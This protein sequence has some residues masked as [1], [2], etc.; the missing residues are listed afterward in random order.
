MAETTTPD[1]ESPY[2]KALREWVCP[3]CLDRRDDNSCGLPKA[4]VCALKRHLPAIV[5]IV[6][7]VRSRRMDEYE[8]AVRQDVCSTCPE[9]SSEGVCRRRDHGDCALYTYLSLVLDA[10]AEVNG[11]DGSEA[12]TGDAPPPTP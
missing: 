11:T 5:E 6:Q 10:I 2:W 8:A 4:Q 3:V 12:A 1:P 9:Q 7:H